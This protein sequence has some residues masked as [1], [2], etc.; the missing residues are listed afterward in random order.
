MLELI[1]T[2][3]ADI[4]LVLV[5]HDIDVVFRV[6]SRIAVMD[7]GVLIAN[8]T[9]QAIRADARVIAAYLGMPARLIAGAGS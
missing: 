9:P 6:C 7:L 4:A 3:H 8:D 5:S 1:T 2:H